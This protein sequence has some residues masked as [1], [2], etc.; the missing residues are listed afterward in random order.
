MLSLLPSLSPL[1]INVTYNFE[2]LKVRKS[3]G[4]MCRLFISLESPFL[5]YSQV[6]CYDFSFS[7]DVC[8]QNIMNTSIKYFMKHMLVFINFI[9]YLSL[10]PCFK[11]CS[12]MEKHNLSF[13]Y[14]LISRKLNLKLLIL[15]LKELSYVE[16]LEF[17]GQSGLHSN[18]LASL[19]Y[20][21]F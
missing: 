7:N 1:E 5:Y 20:T 6:Y 18:F 14:Q 12:K 9:M 10:F 13:K 21:S 2:K 3:H 15:G 17:L 11:P 8:Q 19:K 4:K 16:S